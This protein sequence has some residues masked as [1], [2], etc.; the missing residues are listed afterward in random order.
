MR[1]KKTKV[2]RAI[3]K[4]SAPAECVLTIASTSSSSPE[5]INRI[6]FLK[7]RLERV[8]YEYK[9]RGMFWV[10]TAWATDLVERELCKVEKELGIK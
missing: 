3:N 10:K 7:G 8:K 4:R 1:I 6:V 2:L 9:L 5:F